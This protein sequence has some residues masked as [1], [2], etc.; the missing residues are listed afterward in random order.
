M[1]TYSSQHFSICKAYEVQWTRDRVG[2]SF[3]PINN[4]HNKKIQLRTL[5]K[6]LLVLTSGFKVVLADLVPS[7]FLTIFDNILIF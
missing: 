7:Y 1:T 6:T 3:P 4:N 2:S 5:V